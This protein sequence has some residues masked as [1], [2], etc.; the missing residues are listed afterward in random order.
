[1]GFAIPYDTRQD[2]NNYK[3]YKDN[4]DY[5]YFTPDF[6][7]NLDNDNN[8]ESLFYIINPLEVYPYIDLSS[9]PLLST[10]ELKLIMY[11][12]IKPLTRRI[13]NLGLIVSDT[14][15]IPLLRQQGYELN[16]IVKGNIS[17]RS[18]YQ[19][20]KEY[21]VSDIIL[22]P[23]SLR[24]TYLMNEI[25]DIESDSTR[26]SYCINYHCILNNIN[27]FSDSRIQYYDLLNSKDNYNL[28][29]FN[30]S[31]EDCL[32]RNFIVPRWIDKL[33]K[34]DTYVLEPTNNLFTLLDAYLNRSDDLDTKE[35][36]SIPYRIPI[37]DV[38]NKLLRCRCSEC[39]IR[40]TTCK[41]TLIRLNIL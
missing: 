38:P 5:I 41:D 37:V 11:R 2:I 16:I 8:F 31:V 34:F 3:I 13:E 23:N 30:Y 36:F 9:L 1:M 20:S 17:N 28:D 25:K 15:M 40:C 14:S 10:S 21:D 19:L 26:N 22:P 29:I 7:S 39:D 18:M 4:I 32:R 12:Y 35:L 24:D 33:P 6:I 27:Y